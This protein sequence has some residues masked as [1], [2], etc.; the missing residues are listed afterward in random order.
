MSEFFL[1]YGLFL[2]QTVTVVVAIVFVIAFATSASRKGRE[3]G[4]LVVKSL[5]ERLEKL[6]DILRGELISKKQMKALAKERKERNKK[7]GRQTGDQRRRVFVLDFK[8]DIKASGVAGLREEVNSIVSVGTSDDEVLVRLENAGGLVHEHGLAASQLARIR[9]KGIPLT[10][11]VDKVA[12]SGGYMM[13]CVADT[14][15]AAPFSVVGSIGVLAQIPNFHRLL[16]DHGVEVEQVK[17]GRYKRTVTMFGE[18]SEEDRAKLRE[19]LEEVHTLFRDLIAEY[20]P[21]LDMDQV[22]TGEH[23]LGRRG[24]ELGLVDELGT[25]DDYLL[26]AIDEADLYSVKWQSRKSLQEKLSSVVEDGAASALRGV[27]QHLR[28]SRY[29]V[30]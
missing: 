27:W 7:R 5:N 3:S 12:A 28:N 26:E 2:A 10:V 1:E 25:S 15:R 11:C 13:A 8:G 20:R 24:L 21:G 29:D 9:G 22:G 19:E 17:A 14:I 30:N 6:S 4:G 16:K 18:N 23:W